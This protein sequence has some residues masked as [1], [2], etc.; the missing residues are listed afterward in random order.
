[1]CHCLGGMHHLIAADD[2]NIFAAIVGNVWNVP[3]LFLPGIASC[4]RHGLRIAIVLLGLQVPL[5]DMIDLGWQ[6]LLVVVSVCLG[7]FYLTK[8]AARLMG[9]DHKL[10]ELLA[11]GT[12]ICGAS[13]ILAINTSTQASEEDVAYSLACV[14]LFGSISMLV[15]PLLAQIW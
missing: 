10:G 2:A 14:T 9:V 5:S 6:S 1:I 11:G 4:T 12:A 3:G 8:V 7:T 15:I 13:A